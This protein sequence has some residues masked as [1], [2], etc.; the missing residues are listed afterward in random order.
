MKKNILIVVGVIVLVAAGWFL[1]QNNYANGPTI[2]DDTEEV[3]TNEVPVPGSDV[4]EMIVE[5]DEVQL[6]SPVVSFDGGAYSPSTL[7]IEVGTTVVF[8]NNSESREMWPA[9]ALHPTHTLYPGSSIA[10][11]G[12]EEAD[13]IFDACGVI[14]PGGFYSFTFGEVGEWKYHDH[15]SPSAFGTIVVTE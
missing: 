9:S 12:T 4:D 15:L 6:G 2:G 8:E 7:E 10:K 13:S 5:D 3:V 14:A 1:F 11:C